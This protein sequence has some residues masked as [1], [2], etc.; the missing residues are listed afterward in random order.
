MSPLEKSLKKKKVCLPGDR[1]DAA[2]ENKNLLSILHKGLSKQD[3]AAQKGPCLFGA[4]YDQ[5]LMKDIGR[6]IN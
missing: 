6:I 2:N 5:M 3:V 4:A 1:Y